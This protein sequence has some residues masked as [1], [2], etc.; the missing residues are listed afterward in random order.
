MIDHAATFEATE[1]RGLSR[2]V[3][4]I[5]KIRE[6]G[7]D[8]STAT[9]LGENENVVR[10]VTIHKSKGLEYPVVFVAGVGKQFNTE[11]YTRAKIFK[12]KE[13]GIGVHRTPKGSQLKVKTLATQAVSKK[14]ADESLAEELR[15]LYVALTRAK[16]K[17]ILVGTASAKKLDELQPVDAPDDYEILSAKKFMDWLLPIKD[18]LEPF[19]AAEIVPQSKILEIAGTRKT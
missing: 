11:D 2:F 7:K 17:L 18:A 5:K 1:A 14:I 12:H 16:E 13:F 6:V 10:V 8:L 15:I 9:T 4:F 3:E 19:I